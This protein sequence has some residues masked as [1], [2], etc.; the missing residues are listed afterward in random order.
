MN[1]LVPYAPGN[2]VRRRRRRG[3][4]NVLQLVSAGVVADVNIERVDRRNGRNWYALRLSAGTSDVTARLVGRLRGGGVEELGSILAPAGGIGSGSFAVTTPRTGPYE[5]VVLE[6]R[7]GEMLLHVDAPL[8][9][10]PPA[11]GVLRVAAVLAL[12]GAATL[13]VAMVPF[14]LGAGTSRPQPAPTASTAPARVKRVPLAAARVQSFSARR[15]VTAG[16]RE[17]VLASYLA[18]G[19]RGTIALLDADGVVVATAPFARIGTVRLPVPRA[20]RTLP[21]TAQLT[22]RGGGAK[23]VS[24]VV[25]APNVLATAA[26]ATPAP[27]ASP[28][29][30]AARADAAAGNTAGLLTVQGL[31][32]AGKPLDLRLAAQRAAVRIELED[33]AGATIAETE[34]PAGGTL[35]TLPLPPSAA[36]ATY[37]VALHYTRGG[38]EE[39]FIRTIVAQPH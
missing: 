9:P 22:V 39:L 6:I 13:A 8:P 32:I 33:E 31:A 38:G 27:S 7:S 12:A 23:A 16:E 19:E 24:S 15:D 21:L 3:F 17:T 25:L 29:A 1:S 20:F 30:E 2:V 11:P 35:A 4:S 10:R 5:S 34:V 37:L 36:R 18:V 28:A 26:A 14:A